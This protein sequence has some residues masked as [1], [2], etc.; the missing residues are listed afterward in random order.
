MRF[1]TY[2]VVYT[3]V[4]VTWVNAVPTP[5]R[6]LN[7]DEVRYGPAKEYN[8]IRE[9]YAAQS[10]REHKY[11]TSS[12]RIYTKPSLSRED[13][14]Y[15]ED[16]YFSRRLELDGESEDTRSPDTDLNEQPDINQTAGNIDSTNDVINP[17]DTDSNN[18]PNIK[19]AL[20][21]QGLRAEAVICLDKLL[22]IYPFK[23]I[24]DESQKEILVK[25]VSLI[26]GNSNDERALL[27]CNTIR[28][29]LR[30][31][32]IQVDA[33]VCLTGLIQINL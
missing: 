32:G 26:G 21:S 5:R 11:D 29:H 3:L 33:E 24:R 16:E 4:A 15:G 22:V 1:T 14:S 12:R 17:I 13:Q 31:L 18:C 9:M 10:Y 8:A 30:A 19:A 27:T 25:V 23:A 28:A 20:V 2:A 6:N 7:I